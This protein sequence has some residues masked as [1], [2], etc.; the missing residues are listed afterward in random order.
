MIAYFLE[1][2]G[3]CNWILKPNGALH[4]PFACILSMGLEGLYSTPEYVKKSR[5]I[6]PSDLQ[7]SFQ[8]V[9]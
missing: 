2:Q 7:G 8:A 6:W 5:N 1:V 3:T 4:G 9:R